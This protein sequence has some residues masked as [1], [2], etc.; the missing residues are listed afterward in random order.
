MARVIS[1]ANQKGGVGKTTTAMNL[2]TALAMG[3]QKTLLI[4]I[5]PQAN[6]TS[7][8]GIDKHKAIG[9]FH[10]MLNAGRAEAALVADV[11]DGLDV[12]A[13]SPSLVNLEYTLAT[14]QDR[15]IKLIP[16]VERFEEAYDFV[17]IDCPPSLGLLTKNALRASESVIIPIQCEYYAMEGL[18][19]ILTTIKDTPSRNGQ[20][21][22]IAG[23]LFTMYDRESALAREVIEEVTEHFPAQVYRTKIP[24]DGVLG[25]APS[26]GRSVF[27]YDIRSRAARA[28]ME[29]A[30][31]VIVRG[32]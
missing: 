11:I 20:T 10:V 23:I 28:Y 13:A 31:E 26:F 14:E 5:D 25:E 16:L 15:E 30:R 3:G 12:L 24:R 8:L 7:G 21:V 4:D 17:I 19:Q 6:A 29:L 9:T 32:S 1:V 22:R 2:V 18:T 27:D